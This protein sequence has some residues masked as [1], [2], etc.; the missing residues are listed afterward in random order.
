MRLNPILSYVAL[1]Q[2]A[3]SSVLP[4]TTLGKRGSET[5]EKRAEGTATVNLA[6]TQGTPQHLGA[7]FIYGLPD[8][9]DGSANTAIPVNLRSGSGFKYCRAG[10]AQ[11]P[12][13][14]LG[15]ASGQLQVRL[16]P[17]YLC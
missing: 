17:E 9:E 14:S 12:S 15:Y 7:G 10:G 1:A 5:I 16:S 11:L 2:L 13:P 8:N 4:S 3:A 6:S